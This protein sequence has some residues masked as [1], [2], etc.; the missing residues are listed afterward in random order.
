MRKGCFFKIIIAVIFMILMMT[1]VYAASA[2]IS[3]LLYANYTNPLDG[4]GLKSFN[5]TRL[6]LTYK[7]TLENNYKLRVTTDTFRDSATGRLELF[8]KYAYLEKE[9]LPNTRI[10]AGLIDLPWLAYEEW[11]WGYKMQSGVLADREGYLTSADLGIGVYGKAPTKQI[12]YALTYTNGEGYN[13]AE[14][15]GLQSFDCR[16]TFNPLAPI[17]ISGFMSRGYYNALDQIKNRNIFHVALKT[18]KLTIAGEYLGTTDI[19]GA[20]S[21]EVQ[22]QGYSFYATAKPMEKWLFVARFDYID[23][24][25]N[26]ANDDHSRYIV[27]LGYELAKGILLLFDNEQTKYAPGAGTDTNTAYAHLQAEF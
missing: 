22:G 7:S 5:L 21:T 2:D 6:Y 4:K 8:A 11:I 3:G 13:N 23:P 24:N 17:F 27:G 18:D 26:I 20:G 14:N 9:V 25:Q 19:S 10:K 15:N 1:Q 16:V 12:E